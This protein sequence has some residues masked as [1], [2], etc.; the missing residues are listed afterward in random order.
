MRSAGGALLALSAGSMDN[1]LSE[2]RRRRRSYRR[3]LPA[4]SPLIPRLPIPRGANVPPFPSLPQSPRP[5]PPACRP[6]KA[7]RH[8]RGPVRRYH[9]DPA[10]GAGPPAQP[11]PR[12]GLPS[13][14]GPLRPAKARDEKKRNILVPQAPRITADHGAEAEA[15]QNQ[16]FTARPHA[17]RKGHLGD[18]AFRAGP[19]PLPKRLG[20]V[21]ARPRRT[22]FPG[23][24][25]GP[26]CGLAEARAAARVGRQR[27]MGKTKRGGG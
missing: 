13:M 20:P 15:R 21:K 19:D 5:A 3:T 23:P 25:A 22:S 17:G 12:R 8:T 7:H 9:L 27:R 1:S 10:V 14:R 6:G 18:K 2:R 24:L 4:F 26:M 16:F 11:T